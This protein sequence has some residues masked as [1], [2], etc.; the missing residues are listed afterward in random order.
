MRNKK[1]KSRWYVHEF[2]SRLSR[3]QVSSVVLNLIRIGKPHK[4]SNTACIHKFHYWLFCIQTSRLRR[5]LLWDRENILERDIFENSETILAGRGHLVS[6]LQTSYVDS[7]IFTS[8]VIQEWIAQNWLRTS[9]R[10]ALGGICFLF[11]ISALFFPPT[12][13][14]MKLLNYPIIPRSSLRQFFQKLVLN[15]VCHKRAPVSTRSKL[16]TRSSQEYL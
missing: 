10:L 13:E 1:L 15:M 8:Q 7:T 2:I 16:F 4:G 12:L 11:R 9:W 3:V 6:N 5:S 14:F